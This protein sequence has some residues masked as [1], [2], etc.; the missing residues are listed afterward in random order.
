MR[1][2]N[3]DMLNGKQQ[4]AQEFWMR[5]MKS[6]PESNCSKL[7]NGL[8]IH[9]FISILKCENCN[10]TYTTKYKANSHVVEIRGH[11]TI[12]D[13]V[14]TY[15]AEE[16]LEYR[17][18]NC[19]RNKCR[20]KKKYFLKSAPTC[21][22]LV[23]NR[24]K[25]AVGKKVKDDIELTGQ[26]MLSEF[27]TT[28]HINYKLVTTINHIGCNP[29]QGHY[30]AISCYANNAV[31]EFDDEHVRSID[32]ISGCDAYVLIYELL[33]KVIILSVIKTL[34]SFTITFVLV[35]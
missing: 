27:S 10:K 17:C 6:F 9:D 2:G 25:K 21:L 7:L 4:D 14:N 19:N 30:R 29:F 15:F 18:K 32:K 11:Q 13:A 20:A 26:L 3:A 5:I 1:Q 35:A 34:I 28:D 12:Q 8:F 33:N 23:L 16:T 24:F 22:V 31:Y